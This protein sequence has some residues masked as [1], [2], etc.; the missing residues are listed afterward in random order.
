MCCCLW[1]Q[2]IHPFPAFLCLLLGLTT[3][4]VWFPISLKAPTL[5]CLSMDSAAY[6]LGGLG[7]CLISLPIPGYLPAVTPGAV[8][9]LGPL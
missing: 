7:P 5:L 9:H 6:R 3:L 1:I 4:N 8:L 2:E